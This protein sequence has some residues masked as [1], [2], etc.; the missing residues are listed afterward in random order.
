MKAASKLAHPTLFPSFLTKGNV[1]AKFLQN[2]HRLNAAFS[3]QGGIIMFCQNKTLTL[4]YSRCSLSNLNWSFTENRHFNTDNLCSET[5]CWLLLV[6][7]S[8]A[9]WR[10]S[11]STEAGNT[12][13]LFCVGCEI[14]LTWHLWP[15]EYFWKF[16][17]WTTLSPQR[18]SIILPKGCWAWY[19]LEGRMVGKDRHSSYYGLLTLRMLL[20]YSQGRWST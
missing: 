2:A 1:Q 7:L 16:S 9:A 18:L 13:S 19:W 14:F 11:P 12:I 3:F 15:S 17:R 8:Q 5:L 20:L 4:R 6:M 10:I